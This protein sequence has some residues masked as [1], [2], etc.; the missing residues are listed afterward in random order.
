[1]FITHFSNFNNKRC[2]TN[3]KIQTENLISKI[4]I[5]TLTKGTDKATKCI[6]D[7][8]SFKIKNYCNG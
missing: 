2:L 8:L 5:T 4:M 6:R 7:L 1:M 3:A